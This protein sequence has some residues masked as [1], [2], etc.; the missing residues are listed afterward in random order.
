[1]LS[2][3]LKLYERA[4]LDKEYLEFSLNICRLPDQAKIIDVG[5]GTGGST[6]I[7]M[8][9]YPNA[10]VIGIDNDF[11]VLVQHCLNISD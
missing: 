4:M 1:M 6:K 7:I 8:D 2:D 5:C 10:S 3:L 11:I 9:C